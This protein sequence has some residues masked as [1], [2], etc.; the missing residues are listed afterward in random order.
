MKIY[1]TY[2][3]HWKILRVLHIGFNVSGSYQDRNYGISISLL[4]VTIGFHIYKQ[5]TSE[6]DNLEDFNEPIDKPI[7]L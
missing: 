5:H 2:R 1:W 4:F 3:N 7:K 6:W